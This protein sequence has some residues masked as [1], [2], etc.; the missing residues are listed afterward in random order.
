MRNGGIGPS[1]VSL[2]RFVAESPTSFAIW[3]VAPSC[4]WAIV[5][6]RSKTSGP[7]LTL[8]PVKISISSTGYGCSALALPHRFHW[9][10]AA[11]SPSTQADNN[12]KE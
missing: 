9:N 5:P 3:A 1:G 2:S 12:G 7:S 10:H 4:R 11:R 6:A 8:P